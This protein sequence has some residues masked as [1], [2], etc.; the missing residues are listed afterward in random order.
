MM[1]L[2]LARVLVQQTSATVGRL[3]D[4][5]R[6]RTDDRIGTDGRIP[7]ERWSECDDASIDS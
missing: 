1:V 6:R 7:Q 4:A 3:G 5:V 2:V